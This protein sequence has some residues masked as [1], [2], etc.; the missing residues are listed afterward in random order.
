MRATLLRIIVLIALL[1]SPCHAIMVGHGG[2]GQSTGGGGG[3]GGTSTFVGNPGDTETFEYQAGDFCCTEFSETD[4]DGIIS[5]Y[6]SS[7]P[8]SGTHSATIVFTGAGSQDDNFIQVDLG[9]GDGDFSFDFLVSLPSVADYQATYFMSATTTTTVSSSS[10]GFRLRHNHFGAGTCKIAVYAASSPDD[11]SINL[12]TGTKYRVQVDFNQNAASTV[13]IYNA[14][15][16]LVDTLN[17]TALDYAPQYLN[18]GCLFSNVN[19]NGTYKFDDS[20]L[21]TGGGDL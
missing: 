17:F 18:W 1:F 12:S 8:L 19:A 2:L 11:T 9:S 7:S 5:T 15:D 16:T 10:R 21:K 13:K 20:R 6:D 3:C 4:P 14:S